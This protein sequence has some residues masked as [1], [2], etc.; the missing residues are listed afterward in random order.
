MK[1]ERREGSGVLYT[2]HNRGHEKAPFFTGELKM[3]GDYRQGET[4]K[5]SGWNYQTKSG[6]LISLKINHPI[7]KEGKQEQYPKVISR[8]DEDV[9]F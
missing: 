3:D 7:P 4:I 6:Q 1:E 9:P 2:N 5:L 8:D